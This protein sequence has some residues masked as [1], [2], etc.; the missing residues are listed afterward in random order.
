MAFPGKYAAVIHHAILNLVPAPLAR[1]NLGGPPDRER[2]DN[3][4]LE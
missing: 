3:K 4:A 2:I 1:V